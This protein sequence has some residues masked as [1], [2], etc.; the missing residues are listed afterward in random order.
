MYTN[1]NFL[2]SQICKILSGKV[3]E[4]SSNVLYCKIKPVRSEII[5]LKLSHILAIEIINMIS[6]LGQLHFEFDLR[7][8]QTPNC[9][10]VGYGIHCISNVKSLDPIKWLIYNFLFNPTAGIW[11]IRVLH[12]KGVLVATGDNLSA[13]TRLNIGNNGVILF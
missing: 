5:L 4:Q 12:P 13:S 6:K 11:F 7:S 8:S 1:S 2:S 9:W 10:S 3:N